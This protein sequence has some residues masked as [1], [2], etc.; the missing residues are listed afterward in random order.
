MI[1]SEALREVVM[2]RARE[3]GCTRAEARV[4][5]YYATTDGLRAT[6]RELHLAEQTVRNHSTKIRK[7]LGVPHL[8]AAMVLI[9]TNNK[10]Q[11]SNKQAIQQP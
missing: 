9:F 8:A 4:L 5:G 3:A 10:Y 7:R 2:F 6:A 11:K 1:D